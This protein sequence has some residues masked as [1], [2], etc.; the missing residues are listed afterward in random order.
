MDESHAVGGTND[1]RG[2]PRAVVLGGTGFVGRHL[3]RELS[4]H[5]YEVVVPSR[6]ADRHR[7]MALWPSVVLCDMNAPGDSDL[8]TRREAPELA[9][10]LEGADL[11]VN[12][13]GILNEPRHDGKGFERVHIRLAKAALRAAADAGVP[14][15]LHMSALGADEEKG[16]SFYQ[17]TK[18]KAENW[19]HRFGR[20]H[21]I[22]VTSFRP[23]VIFGPEDAFLNRF[24]ALARL[25]PGIF[26]LACAGARFS[27]VY[28]GDVARRFVEA[29]DDPKTVGERIDLCGPHD[30]SLGDLVR[31][32]AR[33]SGHPRWVL[34][35][36]D[37]ASR[38]Q[39]R[40]LEWM[41]GKP[42]SRDNYDSMRRA[43]VCSPECPREP[44]RLEDVAPR[45]LAP[46][47]PS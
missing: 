31:Y 17:R 27:P 2:L 20:K 6:H 30:Y 12:L 36:P 29:I 43:N 18:G 25:M 45:Y 38:L 3:V 37:W 28:V 21:D 23:S 46:A 8:A 32:A 41:P 15:Y 26:P 4:R 44:T 40:V 10:L 7:D 14:R 5:G 1:P 22:A 39:A 24:A 34:G 42:F 16:T 11:L 9:G 35:L 13:I 47:D 19:V 33:T